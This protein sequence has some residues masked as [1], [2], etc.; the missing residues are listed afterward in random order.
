M[1]VTHRFIRDDRE[2]YYTIR[3]VL[4]NPVE[5]GLVKNWQSWPYTYCA[6]GYEFL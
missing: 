6:P 5:A 3:Y 1:K 4:K 2:Y